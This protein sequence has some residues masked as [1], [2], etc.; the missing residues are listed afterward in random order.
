[1]LQGGF[2]GVQLMRGLVQYSR[3]YIR[4]GAWISGVVSALDSRIS[5]VQ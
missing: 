1:M 5:S 2:L 3:C 4:H